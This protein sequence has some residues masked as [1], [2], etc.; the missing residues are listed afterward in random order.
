[1]NTTI[2]SEHGYYLLGFIS[3]SVNFATFTL[4]SLLAPDIIKKTGLK[5]AAICGTLSHV[6]S[7]GSVLMVYYCENVVVVWIVVIIMYA[8][9]GIGQGVM[10][11]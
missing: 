9:N 1:M 2:F 11:V 5:Q 10:W 8:V 7:N 3:L 6:L 4:G